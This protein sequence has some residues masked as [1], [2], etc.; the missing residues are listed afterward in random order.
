MFFFPEIQKLAL[1]PV[2]SSSCLS[3][4]VG[5]AQHINHKDLLKVDN[6]GTY[7]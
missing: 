5:I 3:C 2:S 7:I 1:S 6:L 4:R